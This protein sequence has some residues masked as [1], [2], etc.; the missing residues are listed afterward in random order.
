MKFLNQFDKI[1]ILE[2]RRWGITLLRI[3]L[4]V[5]FFWFGTLKLLRV[6]PVVS[7]IQQ[8]YFFFPQA[9]FILIL[10]LLEIAI[11][12]GLIFKLWLRVTLALL[13]LQMAG[14]FFSFLLSPEIFFINNNFLLLTLEGEFVVKNLVLVVAAVVV[15]GYEVV[16]SNL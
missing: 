6:S 15:G 14:T 13:W 1:F 2:M 9:E 5:V 11:G 16:R 4:G 12:L 8:T 10:G 3:S 7:L